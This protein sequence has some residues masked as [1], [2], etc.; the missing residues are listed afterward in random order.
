MEKITILNYDLGE[1][2]VDGVFYI[3]SK[4]LLRSFRVHWIASYELRSD[5]AS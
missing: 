1:Y 3:F 2:C 5:A 4:H